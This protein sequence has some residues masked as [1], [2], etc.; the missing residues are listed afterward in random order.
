MQNCPAAVAGVLQEA[1]GRGPI[2]GG[3]TG[4]AGEHANFGLGEASVEKWREDVMFVGS[5][6]AGA[7]IVS[8]VGVDAVGDG[9]ESAF[10]GERFHAV[11]ELVFAVEAAVGAVRDVYGIVEFARFDEFMPDARGPHECGCLFA[12]VA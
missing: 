1:G 3:Q 8:V 2:P 11:E 5:A 10:A 9:A 4:A 7:K 12:I 6:M